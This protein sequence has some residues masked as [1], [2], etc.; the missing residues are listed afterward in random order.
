MCMW[1][2]AIGSTLSAFWILMANSWMQNPVGYTI[3]NGRA[4]MNDFGALITNPNLWVQFPHVFW[5]TLVAAA[6]FVMGV[7]AWHLLRKKG[8]LDFFRRSINIG[9]VVGLIA[10]VQVA[11]AGHAQA[12][13]SIQTQPMKMAAAEALWNSESPASLSIFTI[14][15]EANRADIF[16]IRLPRLLSFLAYD[17]LTGEVKGINQLQAEYEQK[18]GAGDYVPPVWIS[19]WSFRGMVGAGILML[20]VSV[21]ALFLVWRKRLERRRWFLGALVLAMALPYI[22]NIC[23][24]LL[25]ELGR[26]PWVVQGLLKT[27]E[28][29]SP[30]VGV[31]SLVISLVAFTAMYIFLAVVDVFLMLKL[32]KSDP[33]KDGTEA[34]KDEEQAKEAEP[35]LVSAY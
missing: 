33:N 27:E 3:N 4:E 30:A 21:Y 22:A 5:A 16:S 15:D 20:V 14:G 26:Q 10:S 34:V 24:W 29:V 35:I 25:T 12:Q 6:F 19:Y 13:H 8:D 23:G 17:K 2:I 7:S 31:G 1:L 11:F 18:Y 32:A 28:A 9:I